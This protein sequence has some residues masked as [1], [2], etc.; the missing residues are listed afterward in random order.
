MRK[1]SR[2]HLE[3]FVFSL[4]KASVGSVAI[5]TTEGETDTN[6]RQEEVQSPVPF[7][8]LTDRLEL[9]ELK[10]TLS[11][12]REWED[13]D[14]RLSLS[15]VGG[16]DHRTNKIQSHTSLQLSLQELSLKK[17]YDFPCSIFLNESRKELM[18]RLLVNTLGILM[19]SEKS[20]AD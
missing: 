15:H 14:R 9:E 19:D 12:R 10:A 18:I 4:R 16:N 1:C 13:P 17:G 20:L 5:T 11:A 2:D 3:V 6:H 7:S 8:D